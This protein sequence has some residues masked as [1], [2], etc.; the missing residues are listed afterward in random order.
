LRDVSDEMSTEE[1]ALG[2]SVVETTTGIRKVVLP[3]GSGLCAVKVRRGDGTFEY[4]VCDE[5]FQPMY[6]AAADIG[7]LRDRFPR[8]FRQR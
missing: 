1:A 8:A 2:F 5:R 6:V 3:L 7:E 4:E